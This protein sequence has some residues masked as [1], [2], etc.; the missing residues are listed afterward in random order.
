MYKPSKSQFDQI[1]RLCLNLTDL[2]S[3]FER[4]P[5]TQKES[6]GLLVRETVEMLGLTIDPD[7]GLPTKICLICK[8]FL[9]QLY[10]FRNQCQEA[11]DLLVEALSTSTNRENS[12]LI[13]AENV[14][15]LSSDQRQ[16]L[17][18]DDIAQSE[19]APVQ[20]TKSPQSNPELVES[21]VEADSSSGSSKQITIKHEIPDCG[22][23]D[24][25]AENP[26]TLNE[27]YE[28]LD[29]VVE[30]LEEEEII[31][32]DFAEQ[33]ENVEYMI[34]VHDDVLS[35]E[36]NLEMYVDEVNSEHEAALEIENE[37]SRQ[38]GT[39]PV[40]VDTSKGELCKVCGNYS[41]CLKYHMMCHTG[42]RPFSCS[43]CDK[44]FRTSTKLRIHVNGVHLKVRKYTCDICGKKFLDSGNL[45]N[46]KVTH[47]GERKHIC[48]YEGCGKSFRLPGTLTVHKKSHTQEKTFI[49][50]ICSKAFLYKWLLVKH[51]RTHTGEK[52]YEC[53]VCHKRFTTSTHMHTHRKLHDPNRE[54]SVRKR[55]CNNEATV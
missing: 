32:E 36:Q 46:H 55:K 1:C 38:T 20:D 27:E 9:R 16:L 10:K 2:V 50:D 3:L 33:A 29:T 43:H 42:E 11:N 25:E 18:D 47:N 51:I 44:S 13:T 48:D 40:K 45:R 19:A 21:T 53:D 5:K 31:H 24:C 6:L 39:E 49:C 22:E 4:H 28:I 17:K 54:K 41:T 8:S 15:A 12:D 26:E 14:I 37:A 35:E 34:E 30:E 23:K 52:P 7:D